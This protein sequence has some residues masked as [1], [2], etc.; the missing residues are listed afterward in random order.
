MQTL[1]TAMGLL[2]VTKHLSCAKQRRTREE[3]SRYVQ[4][5]SR[6]FAGPVPKGHVI[7]VLSRPAPQELHPQRL[8]TYQTIGEL[9]LKGVFGGA[10]VSRIEVVRPTL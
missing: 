9:V 6:L 2:M 7:A 5:A 10:A 1:T 8:M 4:R 3:W